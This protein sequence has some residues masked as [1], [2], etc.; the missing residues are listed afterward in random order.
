MQSRRWLRGTAVQRV[1]GA[2]VRSLA[3]LGSMYGMVPPNHAVDQLLLR[4]APAPPPGT[5]DGGRADPWARPMRPPARAHPERLR[6]DIPLSE[7]ELA[8]QEELAHLK[9]LSRLE[10]W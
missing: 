2:V 3:I 4:P 10:G 1:L 5:A 8:L 6:P 7:T 9:W